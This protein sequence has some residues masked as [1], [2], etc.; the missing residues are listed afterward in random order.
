M[1]GNKRVTD[2]MVLARLDG[3]KA[4]PGWREV[5]V[6]SDPKAKLQMIGFDSKARVQRRYSA[7]FIA[8]KTEAK[9]VRVRKFGKDIGPA[10]VRIA[11]EAAAGRPEALLT[12]L[13]DKTAI[14]IGT[15]KD[16]NAKVKA[17]GLTTLEGRHVTVRQ[18]KFIDFD[19][20]GKEGKRYTN[21]IQDSQLGAFIEARKKAAGSAGKLFP[22]VNDKKLNKY[23]KDT[24]GPYSVKDFRTYHA[25]RIAHTELEA[26]ATTTL[27]AKQKKAVVDDVLAKASGFLNNTPVMAKKSYIDPT[28]WQ[29]IGGID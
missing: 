19:F 1:H 9:F 28:V 8:E 4:P 15:D 7:E 22:D 17:Y 20:I 26:Y 12:R 27:T 24:I 14:R 11:K 16:I 6:S 3:L 25:T 29:M 13:E 5:H 10:R 23:V 2:K 18:G 21:T